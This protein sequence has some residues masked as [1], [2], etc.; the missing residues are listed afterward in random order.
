VPYVGLL[1]R[2]EMGAKRKGSA[3]CHITLCQRGAVPSL[4]VAFQVATVKDHDQGL[5]HASVE[6][7]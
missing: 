4:A 7:R 5:F 2:R 6:Q 3:R 1:N